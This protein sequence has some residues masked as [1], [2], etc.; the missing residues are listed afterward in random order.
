[1]VLRR[2]KSGE[3]VVEQGCFYSREGGRGSM[4]GSSIAIVV[5]EWLTEMNWCIVG[6]WH[7]LAEWL[8][9]NN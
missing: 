3:E 8:I 9:E 2:R 6:Q 1:M 4:G 5:M 7:F